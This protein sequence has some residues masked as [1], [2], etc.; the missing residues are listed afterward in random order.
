MCRQGVGLQVFSSEG[1]GSNPSPVGEREKSRKCW[2]GV[3]LLVFSAEDMGSNPSPVN[4]RRVES[5][6]RVWGLTPVF[7]QRDLLQDSPLRVTPRPAAR[8]EETPLREKLYGDLMTL[9]TWTS[10]GSDRGGRRRGRS[11]AGLEAAVF[12]DHFTVRFESVG[13]LWLERASEL[14]KR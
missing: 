13:V 9:K 11:K 10:Q 7:V 14:I 4:E 3:G 8:P 5:A 12:K 1:I 2:Q 6:G